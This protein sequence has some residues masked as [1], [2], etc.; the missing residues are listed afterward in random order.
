MTYIFSVKWE[1]L[2]HFLVAGE[3]RKALEMLREIKDGFG[4]GRL[5]GKE[6]LQGC[7]VKAF[8]MES[9]LSLAYG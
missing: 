7:W 6:T 8:V 9:N 4:K 5:L 2:D 3:K 1:R